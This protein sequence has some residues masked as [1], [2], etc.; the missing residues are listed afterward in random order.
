MLGGHGTVTEMLGG[1]LMGSFKVGGYPRLYTIVK[2]TRLD[3]RP[4]AARHDIGHIGLR[5]HLRLI[6]ASDEP[7]GHRVRWAVSGA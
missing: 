2:G 7:Y 5:F 6:A 4:A 3:R 1:H